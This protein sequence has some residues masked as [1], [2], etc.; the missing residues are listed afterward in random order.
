MELKIN[1]EYRGEEAIEEVLPQQRGKKTKNKNAKKEIR[2][3]L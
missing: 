2:T 1:E 3:K